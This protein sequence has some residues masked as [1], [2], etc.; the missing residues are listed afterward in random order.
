MYTDAE[1]K[2][3]ISA[4]LRERLAEARISDTEFMRR[5]GLR[6][7]S[8]FNQV[9]NGT[10]SERYPLPEYWAQIAQAAGYVQDRHW[11]HFDFSHYVNI[12]ALCVRAHREREVWLLDGGTGYGKSY[13]LSSYCREP[14][15]S[16]K[17]YYY[18]ASDEHIRPAD[19]MRGL[20]GEMGIRKLS[21]MTMAAMTAKAIE[22]LREKGG[23]LVADECEYLSN[24][25]LKQLRK[26]VYETEGK[27]G[28]IICGAGMAD[29]MSRLA[30]RRDALRHGWAQFWSRLRW[31]TRELGQIGYAPSDQE[32]T[33][34]WAAEVRQVCLSLGIS[35]SRAIAWLASRTSSYRD[36]NRII[37]KALHTSETSG[38]EVLPELLEAVT[39]QTMDA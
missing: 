33:D 18:R 26:L 34:K 6:S 1:I 5:H 19:L 15:E 9:K 35:S 13:A 21:G 16:G 3:Q 12:R 28:I 2:K 22:V 17:V 7:E 36:L 31:N 23:L 29:R 39:S 8:Y 10:Y 20:L 4:L 27:A 38:M 30:G 37:T 14:E 25:C 11:R 32:A 24:A